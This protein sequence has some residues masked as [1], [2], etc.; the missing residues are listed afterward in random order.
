MDAAAKRA[1]EA[2][3]KILRRDAHIVLAPEIP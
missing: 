1:Q 2:G 3:L